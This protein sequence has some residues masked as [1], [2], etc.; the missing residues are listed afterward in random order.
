LKDDENEKVVELKL[1]IIDDI[2]ILLD[3]TDTARNITKAKRLEEIINYAFTCK[4]KKLKVEYCSLLALMLQNHKFVQ[5]EAV[6]LGIYK[7]IPLIYSEQDPDIL[8]KYLYVLGGMIYGDYP[9]G[10]KIFLDENGLELIYTLAGKF[11]PYLR[12]V[13]NIFSELTKPEEEKEDTVV[14]EKILHYLTSEKRYSIFLEMLV[15]SFKEDPA[16]EDIRNNLYHLLRNIYCII[17]EEEMVK[18]IENCTQQLKGLKLD[19]GQTESELESL[20]SLINDAK[21]NKGNMEESKENKVNVTF[22]GDHKDVTLDGK[23][24]SNVKIIEKIQK[25]EE[26]VLMLAKEEKKEEPVLM[27]K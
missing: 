23:D 20:N 13:I 9:K 1:F 4:N 6:K 15:E 3:S 24:L 25:K 27:L 2:S 11:T 8:N 21:Q 16:Y 22:L 17:S 18:V 5:E 7:I 12:R 19:A 10:R 26:P 14:R